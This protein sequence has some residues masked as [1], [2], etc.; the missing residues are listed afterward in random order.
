MTVMLAHFYYHCLISLIALLLLNAIRR[1]AYTSLGHFLLLGALGTFAALFFALV[2]SAEIEG[3]AHQHLAAHA[4]A[5]YGSFFLFAS[6]FLMY[7]QKKEKGKPR[8]KTPTVILVIG[9]LYFGLAVHAFFIEPTAL[10]VRE[11]VIATPKITEPITIVFCADMQAERVGGYERRTLQKIKEQHA[12]LILFGGDYIQH[13]ETKDISALLAEWNQLFREM[14]L[15]APLGVYAVQGNHEQRH[16]WR[17]MFENTAIIPRGLTGTVQA[18]EIRIT[19]LSV[20]SSWANRPVPDREQRDNFRIIVGHMPVFA[21]AEQE[22][23]L[24]LAG[25]THGGQIQIP[26]FGPLYTNA[27]DL[28][29]RWASGITHLPNGA[30]LIVTHGSGLARGNAPQVRFWCRPDFWV[31]RLIPEKDTDQ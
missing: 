23:D 1:S 7:R 12:D 26:F 24:L 9:C 15:Q 30:T 16:P 29:R 5:W 25:H 3:L 4:L 11:T 2:P 17:E 14:D 27:K 8:R 18:G 21:M 10:V 28:P 19:F 6:A 20:R 22:A 13:E 31:I